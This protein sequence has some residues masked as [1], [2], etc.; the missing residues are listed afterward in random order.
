MI[1]ALDTAMP[2][3][4]VGAF[5]L[6]LA[7]AAVVVVGGNYAHAPVGKDMEVILEQTTV[8]HESLDNAGK[9]K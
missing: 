5:F 3:S 4:A 1:S 6:T 2:S 9:A 7:I 8:V